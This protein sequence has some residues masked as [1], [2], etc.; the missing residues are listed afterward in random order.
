MTG[1]NTKEKLIEAALKLMLAKG[2]PATTVDEICASAGV[3][4]GSF[5]HFFAAK[6]DLALAALEAYSQRG[7]GALQSG[8]YTALEDPLE[9]A[10]GFLDH[11]QAIAQDIWG[12]GCLLGNL[13]VELADT[14]ETIRSRI[15]AIFE[16]LARRLAQVF[17]VVVE[18]GDPAS[19]PP[20]ELAE[21]FLSAL[22]GSIVLAK[23]HDDWGRVPA[24]LENFRRYLGMLAQQSAR[25]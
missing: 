13:A 25:A 10:F 6:E 2:Y 4:K 3:S 5:Y 19:P 16:A 7:F 20:L 11:A 12:D 1:K 24:A 8:S 21:F 22:E 17:E 23:A 9:R 18:P 14:N 15:S